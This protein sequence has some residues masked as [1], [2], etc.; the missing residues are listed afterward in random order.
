MPTSRSS[1]DGVG[2]KTVSARARNQEGESMVPRD[3]LPSVIDFD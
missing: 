3:R 1:L 2:L